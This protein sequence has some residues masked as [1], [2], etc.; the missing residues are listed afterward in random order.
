MVCSS[1]PGAV[2][3]TLRLCWCAVD[4]GLCFG[5]GALIGAADPCP[6]GQTQD[7]RRTDIIHLRQFAKISSKNTVKKFQKMKKCCPQKPPF[8]AFLRLFK[9]SNFQI[10]KNKQGAFCAPFCVILCSV[11]SVVPWPFCDILLAGSAL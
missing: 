8:C 9:F 3:V 1:V 2:A 7:R 4:P 6:P 10:F 11:V 5:A